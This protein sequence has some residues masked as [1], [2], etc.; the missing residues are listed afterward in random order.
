MVVVVVVVVSIV[1]VVVVVNILVLNSSITTTV[2]VITLL[3]YMSLSLVTSYFV[4][5]G[6]IR[7]LR[8]ILFCIIQDKKMNQQNT[9]KQS[10]RNYHLWEISLGS[11]IMC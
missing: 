11:E 5:Q 3:T 2:I 1:I 9:G 8:F 4:V 7:D 10:Y 6:E